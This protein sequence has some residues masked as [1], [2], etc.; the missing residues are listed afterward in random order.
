MKKLLLVFSI[1]IT[2]IS[3]SASGGENS[4][5]I[6]QAY[7]SKTGVVAMSFSKEMFDVFDFDLDTDE[8][9]KHVSGDF[10]NIKVLIHSPQEE[11][12][13]YAKDIRKKLES[14]NYKQVHWEDQEE[15]IWVFVN[16]KSK[17]FEEVHILSRGESSDVLISITGNFVITDK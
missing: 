2:S 9:L 3:L 10:K 17:N 4:H 1:V 16:K 7:A 11:G 14:L 12:L 8:I 15:N 5:Q 13:S 6:H